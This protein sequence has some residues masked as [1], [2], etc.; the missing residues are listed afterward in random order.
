MEVEN[1][2]AILGQIPLDLEY[3]CIEL[4]YN[5]RTPTEY[6]T[7]IRKTAVNEMK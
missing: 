2:A 7:A 5:F 4:F 3:E 6:V 1:R